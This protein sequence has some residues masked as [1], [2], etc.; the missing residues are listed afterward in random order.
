MNSFYN[1]LLIGLLSIPIG[2]VRRSL[3]N[4]SFKNIT[5]SPFCLNIDLLNDNWHSIACSKTVNV[6][7]KEQAIQ[8]P[9][10]VQTASLH[11][12]VPFY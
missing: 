4:L 3:E 2:P 9:Q 10:T 5:F 1:E 6:A 12:F 7:L 8:K 11:W